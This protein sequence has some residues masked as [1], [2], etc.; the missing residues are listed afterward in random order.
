M[1][2]SDTFRPRRR[3]RLSQKPV[4]RAG[5]R[6]SSDRLPRSQGSSRRVCT[7]LPPSEAAPRTQWAPAVGAPP[8]PIY[9]PESR[10]F[11]LLRAALQGPELVVAEPS[12]GPNTIIAVDDFTPVSALTRWDL[13]IGTS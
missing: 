3:G 11:S 2:A 7:V 13:L 9:L 8:R 10:A 4:E 12:E 1:P 5:R 6:I